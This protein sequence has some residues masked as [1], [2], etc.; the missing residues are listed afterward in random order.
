VLKNWIFQN[1]HYFPSQNF[2]LSKKKKKN[3]LKKFQHLQ[4]KYNFCPS[5]E[6]TL[7]HMVLVS[8]VFENIPVRYDLRQYQPYTSTSMVWDLRQF[9]VQNCLFIPVLLL[10][11]RFHL[12]DARRKSALDLIWVPDWYE[13]FK[14]VTNTSKYLPGMKWKKPKPWMLCS[15]SDPGLNLTLYAH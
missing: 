12:P 5:C 11:T 2:V 3:L 13:S 7:S 10:G 9:Q 6:G 14:L 8:L 4:K 15:Q 1:I